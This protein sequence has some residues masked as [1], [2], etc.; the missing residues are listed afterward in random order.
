MLG[1]YAERLNAVEINGSFYRT[2]PASTLDSW[3]AATPSGFKFCFKANR[4][5][6]YSAA[7]FDKVGLATALGDHLR[8]LGDRLGPVLVQFPP[9]RQLDPGLL[10]SIL[11]ALGLRAAVEFRHASWFE[12]AVYGLLREHGAAL[13]VTD[14]EKWPAA[15]IIEAPAAYFRLRRDYTEEELGA[16]LST[17]GR[18][19]STSEEVYVFFKHEPEAPGRALKTLAAESLVETRNHSSGSLC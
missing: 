12:P 2:T 9:T 19:A 7:A 16:W 13:V 17:I 5:V 1:Y 3:A 8:R 4:G 14:E 10:A 18:V 6:T 15:P 11:S